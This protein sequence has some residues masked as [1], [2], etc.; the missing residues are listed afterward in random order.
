MVCRPLAPLL[1]SVALLPAQSL[2]VLPGSHLAR[3]GSTGTNVPFGRGTPV[4]VQCAYDPLLFAGPVVVT[5][6]ALRL[7]GNT[8]AAGKQVDCEL[9]MSTMVPTLV[10]IGADFAGN[11]GGDETVVLPRQLLA[12]PAQTVASSPSPF[13][14]PI[15]LATPFPFDPR[16]GALLLEIV[17]FGQPPGAFTL[18]ATWVCDSPEVLFGPLPCT[19]AAGLPLRVESATTQVMWGRPWIVRTL[20]A[21]PGTL[22]T[23]VLGTMESG[24][25]SGVDLPFDLAP[26]GAPGCFIATDP[27][28]SFFQTT[29]GDGTA[30]FTFAI[31]NVPWA[32]G[33][34]LRFQA[35]AMLASANALGVV[36]SQAKKVQVCGFEPVARVWTSDLTAA[37]GVRELGVAP[38]VQLTVR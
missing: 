12:L 14:P 5:H 30:S 1:L 17:V 36:T 10:N 18:D 8:T 23:L 4:R 7:D 6:V 37:I 24:R 25:W 33:S 22:V 28:A 21:P 26:L 11:R 31:P 29:A 20:D 13:L 15:A 38:V 16:G 27:M 19:P 35:G 3:E 32:I 9:R 34:W 2:L